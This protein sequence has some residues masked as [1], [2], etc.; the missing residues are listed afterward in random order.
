V[1]PSLVKYAVLYLVS[2]KEDYG[3]MIG[4]RMETRFGRVLRSHPHHAHPALRS[5]EQEG[6]IE[7]STD[8]RSDASKRQPKTPYRITP[9]GETELRR[10]LGSPLTA[11]MARREF[12]TRLLCI[13]E[14]DQEAARNVLDLYE[15]FITTET[16]NQRPETGD[17]PVGALYRR[18][19][20]EESD[21][22]LAFI[23]W[24]RSDLTA[25]TGP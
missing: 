19:A 12:E 23:R 9:A 10:W 6:F 15:L 24:A 18:R 14:D 5:L 4:R 11:N 17:D 25:Q 22:A 1:S 7:P 3:A 2:Q 13:E 20:R 8:T 21:A 16:Q